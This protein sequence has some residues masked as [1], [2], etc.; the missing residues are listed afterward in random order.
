MSALLP[1][2]D[3]S[4]KVPARSWSPII[5]TT[6]VREC[7]RGPRRRLEIVH[8]TVARE[9]YEM[10]KAVGGPITDYIGMALNHY[11]HVLKK[12]TSLPDGKSWG[13]RRGPVISFPCALPKDLLDEVRDLPG[14][15]DGHAMEAVR[16]FFRAE[17]AASDSAC[18]PPKSR[19]RSALSRGLLFTTYGGLVFFA[20]RIVRLIDNLSL[21]NR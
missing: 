18:I 8:V 19:L 15:F 17:N 16:L 2:E 6:E 11:V 12:V 5:M 3:L 13:W 9:D 20:S 21:V 14:R 1:Q 10:L 7:Q 4:S